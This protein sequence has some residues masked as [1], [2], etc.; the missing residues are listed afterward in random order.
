MS[1][2]WKKYPFTGVQVY[3]V[4]H[5]LWDVRDARETK[6]GFDLLFGTPV[7]TP[8]GSST[9]GLPRLI[10]TDALRDYWERNKTKSKGEVYD[11][12]AGRT[13]L[14]R[15]RKRLGLNVKKDTWTFYRTH[16]VELRTLS[17]SEFAERYGIDKH[18]VM[19]RRLRLL[20]RKA[21]M[22]GWW[23]NEKVVE[24]LREPLT[25]RAAGEKLGIKITHVARLRKQLQVGAVAGEEQL[26]KAA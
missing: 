15:V 21:R 14:K 1:N 18:V 3:D 24:I 6:H 2:W 20:G 11:L 25:L 16:T 12:P 17:A 5:S 7:N 26:L 4:D 22:I 13:T 23:K 19:H 9:N 8:L 10:A